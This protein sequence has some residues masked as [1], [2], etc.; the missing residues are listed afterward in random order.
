MVNV[1]RGHLK[2]TWTKLRIVQLILT[3]PNT[4]ILLCSVTSRLVERELVDIK[5][6]L[7]DPRIL[8]TF[9][10]EVP[11]PGKDYKNWEKST[12][13]ELTVRHDPS[14]GRVPQEPQVL[15]VGMGAQITGFHFDW[16]FLD[17]IVDGSNVTTVDQME[18]TE[19]WWAYLTP[20]LE[21]DAVTIII[22]TR[23]HM[24]DLYGLIIDEKQFDR[25]YVRRCIEQG[26]PIY[27]AWFTLKSLEKIRKRMRDDWKFNCQYNNDPQ[28]DDSK[29]FRPP[30]LTFKN[31]PAGEYKYYMSVDPAATTNK[32]SDFSGITVAAVNELNALFIVE[33]T[34][35]KVPGNE[36][37]EIIMQKVIRYQPQRVGIELG[38]QEHLRHIIDLKVAEWEGLNH[39]PKL[40]VLHNI[41]PIKISREKSKRQRIAST[42]GAFVRE[43]KCAIHE[44]QIALMRQMEFF[45]GKGKEHDDLVDSASMIF[46]V[47]DQFALHYWI[48]PQFRKPGYTMED[49]KKKTGKGWEAKFVA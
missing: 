10:E 29:I 9:K 35:H 2:S 22:G 47:S 19:D 37:A 4:R 49:F 31:L 41:L 39:S 33:C 25:I 48:D 13:N 45:T 38:L 46:A 3:D 26:T 32:H 42:L 18:K 14:L 23:Y 44:S 36:L 17:D 20:I 8:R 11:A 16:A 30:F 24:S 40:G 43:R 15:A 1:P 7:A 5:A 12:A 28:P 21:A 34:Q 27:N 6:I